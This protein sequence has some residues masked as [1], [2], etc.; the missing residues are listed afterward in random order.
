M[1]NSPLWEDN[2]LVAGKLPFQ[3]PESIVLPVNTEPL[4]DVVEVNVQGI[5]VMAEVLAE[6]QSEE[7]L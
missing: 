3:K 6:G 1:Q 2:I 7:L 5:R 4:E